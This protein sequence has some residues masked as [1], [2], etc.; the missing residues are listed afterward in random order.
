MTSRR[1]Y[2]ARVDHVAELRVH[3]H[4]SYMPRYY[5]LHAADGVIRCIMPTNGLMGAH[6]RAVREALRIIRDNPVY[7]PHRQKG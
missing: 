7:F 3:F 2:D 1:C 5:T 6:A 4:N